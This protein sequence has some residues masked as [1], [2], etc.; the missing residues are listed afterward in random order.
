MI[1]EN[2]HH[3]STSKNTNLFVYIHDSSFVKDSIY[4]CKEDLQKASM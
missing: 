3:I 4:L 2:I 1:P